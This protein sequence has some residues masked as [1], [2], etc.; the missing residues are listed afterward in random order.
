[1]SVGT[2]ISNTSQKAEDYYAIAKN[3]QGTSAN[4]GL[5]NASNWIKSAADTAINVLQS[6][7]SKLPKIPPIFLLCRIMYLPGLSATALAA[8]VVNELHRHGFMTEVNFDGS[9]NC[10]VEFVEIIAQK[11]IEEIKDNAKVRSV[12]VTPAGP[13]EIEGK[14]D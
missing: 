5:Q 3:P 13:V 11:F 9:K 4:G 2:F 14:V 1:M 10:I 6:A 12:M 7:R 8:Q